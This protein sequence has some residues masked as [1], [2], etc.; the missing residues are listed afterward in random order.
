MYLT[1]QQAL[2]LPCS[3]ETCGDWH[4]SALQWRRLHLR[5]SERSVFADYGIETGV[6]VPEHTKKYNVAN[7]IR[8]LLDLLEEGKFSVAQGMNRDYICNDRYTQEV[9]GNVV[10][11]R[12]LPH[13][14]GIDR[15]MG[16]EYLGKWLDY[17]EKIGDA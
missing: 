11:L 10:R 15:F 9:F 5:S 1:G 12:G 13:W 2:N 7:H 3:L 14:D 16:R 6:S 8:A 17:K 4:G